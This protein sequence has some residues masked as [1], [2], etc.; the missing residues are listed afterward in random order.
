MV[1]ISWCLRQKGGLKL[2]EPNAR[3]ASSYLKMS[4]GA[5][6]TMNRE[7]GENTISSISA[8]YY[9]IYYSLYAIMQK[10]GVKSEIHSCSIEF[11][12][13]FLMDFYA[14]EDID[15]IEI[16]FFSRNTLQYYADKSVNQK[17]MERVWGD[18]YGFFVKSRGILSNLTE[19]KING[20]RE[21]LNLGKA[22]ASK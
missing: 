13:N 17:D 1:K 11:M 6:G 22:G 10:I 5:V 7:K 9:A 12:K 16:A 21:K 3:L 2:V 8:G 15:L 4:E 14:E 20:I 18:A 19:K